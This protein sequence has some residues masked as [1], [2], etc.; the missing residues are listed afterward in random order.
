MNEMNSDILLEFLKVS[1]IL[2][3]VSYRPVSD[4]EMRK[5]PHMRI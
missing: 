2:V 5:D 1:A 3:L 4:K